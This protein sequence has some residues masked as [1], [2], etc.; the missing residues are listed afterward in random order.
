MH[1]NTKLSDKM[2]DMT[3][4]DDAMEQYWAMKYRTRSGVDWS[5]L[6]TDEDKFAFRI[7][8]NEGARTI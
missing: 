4:S 6:L 2:K 3:G 8:E 5:T 1:S 7:L